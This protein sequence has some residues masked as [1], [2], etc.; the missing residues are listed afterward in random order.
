M[1][2][3]FENA[4]LSKDLLDYEIDFSVDF[5][6]SYFPAKITDD[7]YTSVPP[8][9][10]TVINKINVTRCVYFNENGEPV[11]AVMD[12]DLIDLARKYAM[13]NLD[14]EAA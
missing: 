8:Q 4:I 12:R 2:Q 5:D 1:T 9:G 13:D 3:T 11:D 14:V 7:P 10:E 6:Y